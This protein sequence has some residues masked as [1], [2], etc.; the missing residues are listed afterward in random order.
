MMVRDFMN[1]DMK[2]RGT[3]LWMLNDKLEEKELER[4]I[5]EMSKKGCGS[6]ITRT[7]RGL[8]SDY[9]GEEFMGKM[10]V[11][12]NKAKETGMKIFLQA[13]YMPGGIPDLPEE[14]TH[15]VIKVAEANAE[16]S[17]PTI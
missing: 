1:V 3:D 2:Y 15:T 16:G 4:Q 12:I 14:Y 10:R 8:K 13:G 17:Q 9:P 6:F 11:I 7:F 5:E